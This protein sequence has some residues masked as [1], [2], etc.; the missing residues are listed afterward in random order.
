M[1]ETKSDFDVLRSIQKHISRLKPR[2][3]KWAVIGIGEYA[4]DIIFKG[5]VIN[6]EGIKIL[7]GR[8]SISVLESNKFSHEALDT[9]DIEGNYFQSF[10]WFNILPKTMKDDNFVKKLKDKSL[11][12]V[13]NAL[14]L[15]ATWDGIGSGFPSALVSRFSS[16]NI[17]SMV[18]AL[19]PSKAQPPVAHFNALA[20]VGLCVNK[21]AVPTLLI[22][23]DYLENYI[24][25]CRKGAIVKGREIINI[26]IELILSKETF[27]EEITTLSKSF[28]TKV[29]TVLLSAGASLRV[30]GSLHN[31]FRTA[32]LRPLLNFD[33]STATVVYVISRIPLS[34]R[35]KLSK[36][37]IEGATADWFK[38]LSSLKSI[39]VSD[40]LFVDDINDRI[41]IAIFIGGFKTAKTLSFSKEKCSEL[42]DDMVRRGILSSEEWQEIV[43]DL[44]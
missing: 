36:E 31:I 1:S 17:K 2:F 23:R 18:V 8:P 9:L 25:V 32:L 35:N 3:P 27:F 42:K 10:F 44:M 33:L 43:K 26:L 39:H 13:R 19:L 6:G 7:I 40:P 11:H 38:E 16:W 30:Y 14:I 4:A 5:V 29:Y 28:D 12:T 34:L 15:S 24:G 20:A 37:H 41:D 22:D 21:G